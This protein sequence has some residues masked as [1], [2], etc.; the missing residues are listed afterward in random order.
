MLN[1]LDTFGMSIT[2]YLCKY[3]NTKSKLHLCDIMSHDIDQFKCDTWQHGFFLNKK[4][5]E[6]E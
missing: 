3:K 2:I 5:F 6:R 4:R 1:F